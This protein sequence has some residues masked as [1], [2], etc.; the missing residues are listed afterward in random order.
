METNSDGY[1]LKE[2]VSALSAAILSKHP[3]MPTL[4]REIHST[5]SKYPEQVTLMD[6]ESI[7]TIVEGLKIQTGISFAVAASSAKP[8]AVKNL[9]DKIGKMGAD[10]F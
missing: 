6:E 2:K 5:L 3:T 1:I 7:N 10:A 9:K 4:L 8:S